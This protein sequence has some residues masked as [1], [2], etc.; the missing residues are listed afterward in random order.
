MESHRSILV[1][2]NDA[3]DAL[4]P[5]LGDGHWMRLVHLDLGAR[6]EN[7]MLDRVA[8]TCRH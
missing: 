6:A 2:N 1:L 5:K 4:A 3:R 8:Q 7:P